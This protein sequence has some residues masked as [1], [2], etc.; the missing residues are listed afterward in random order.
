MYGVP[1]QGGQPKQG[2]AFAATSA[3]AISSVETAQS[4]LDFKMVE[5]AAS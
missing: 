5:N 2:P 1:P 4:E 3:E